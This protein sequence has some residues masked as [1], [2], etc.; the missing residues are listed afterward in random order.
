MFKMALSMRLESSL[1]TLF[2]YFRNIELNNLKRS[3][4]KYAYPIFWLPPLLVILF[5]SDERARSLLSPICTQLGTLLLLWRSTQ[6]CSMVRTQ[7]KLVLI[8]FFFLQGW[9]SM[10]RGVNS[11]VSHPL[12]CRLDPD[13]GQSFLSSEREARERR[14]PTSPDVIG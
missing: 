3:I 2:T 5:C 13:G 4:L 12:D 6:T 9:S 1:N 10:D 11:L 8:I 7:I 14:R